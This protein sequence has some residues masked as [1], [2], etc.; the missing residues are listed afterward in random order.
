MLVCS[1]NAA[2]VLRQ[3]ER[4]DRDLR[5]G[6]ADVVEETC[7][8]GAAHAR[9]VG[10]FKDHTGDLRRGIV[11]FLFARTANGAR[12]EIASVV[13]YSSYVE[14]GTEPHEIRPK[15]GSTFVGPLQQGQ[16]RRK[17]TDIGTHRTALRWFEGGA[18]RFARVVHHPGSRPYPFMGPAYLKA[19]Q[20][21]RALTERHV[22]RVLA[23][24][25]R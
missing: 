20:L 11:G 25:S 8:G 12:G 23:R 6:L 7:E 18:V 5:E 13:P 3:L 16:S 2:D 10:Q 17:G 19:Q 9:A 4:A 22:A 21:L 1:D 15:E 14:A 24:L